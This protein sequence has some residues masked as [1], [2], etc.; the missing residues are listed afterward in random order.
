MSSG[1]VL[2]DK[3]LISN[4]LPDYNSFTLRG[5]KFLTDNLT[6]SSQD[7]QSVRNSTFKLNVNKF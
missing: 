6:S 3:A 7:S 4:L 5:T 1:V 2:M